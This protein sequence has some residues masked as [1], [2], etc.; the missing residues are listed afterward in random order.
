[1]NF[2]ELTDEQA[3]AMN[4]DYDFCACLEYN[5]Q[6]FNLMDVARVLAVIEGEND[7]EDWH[8]VVR[9]RDRRFVYLRG[10]CD[11]TGWDCRSWADSVFLGPD[12]RVQQ[13]VNE[14]SPDWN[15]E[16]TGKITVDLLRQLKTQKDQTWREQKDKEFGI[17]DNH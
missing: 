6:P 5:P 7:R 14:L 11:Y 3:T 2:Y 10:G 9:L 4:V 17:R 16:D 15:D 8:W 1:M 12:K 13:A